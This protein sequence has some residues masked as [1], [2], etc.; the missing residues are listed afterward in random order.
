MMPGGGWMCRVEARG[1]EKDE[2]EVLKAADVEGHNAMYEEGAEN[3]AGPEA[4]DRKFGFES[5]RGG[6]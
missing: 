4:T 2:P 1:G 5:G 3:I 6:C